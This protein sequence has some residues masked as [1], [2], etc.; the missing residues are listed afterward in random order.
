MYTVAHGF[1][2]NGEAAMNTKWRIYLAAALLTALAMYPK[3]AGTGFSTEGVVYWIV[4]TLV[5]GAVWGF[6]GN[7]VYGRWKKTP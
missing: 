6:I 4:G 2:A 5:G 7:W 3:A 1:H